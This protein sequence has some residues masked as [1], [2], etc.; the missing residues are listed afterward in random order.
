MLAPVGARVASWS[1]VRT[2]P[3]ALRMRSFAERVNRRAAIDS[4]GMSWNRTSSVTVP[5]VTMIFDS[6]SSA[7]AVSLTMREREMGGRLIF[8]WNRRLRITY[9]IRQA[10]LLPLHIVL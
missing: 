9:R 5:T 10:I 7:L 1:R 3:P 2:S 6:R 8:D 4:F